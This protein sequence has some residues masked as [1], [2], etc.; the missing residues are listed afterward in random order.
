MRTWFQMSDDKRMVE[1]VAQM[2]RGI[3]DELAVNTASYSY[4]PVYGYYPN[5]YLT[6]C[7][8]ARGWRDKVEPPDEKFGEEEILFNQQGHYGGALSWAY[9]L[10][11]DE[12]VLEL[13][14]RFVNFTLLPKFWSDWPA[15]EYPYVV[16]AEHAHWQGHWHGYVNTLRSVLEYARI[17][18]DTRLLQFVRDGY[19]WARQK[20]I[21][22]IGYVPDG[23]GCALG[24]LIGLAVQMSMAA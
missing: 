9:R 10:T 7:Y 24:R 23:Q 22:R 11:N 17:V 5:D 19:E 6:A 4:I 16:G 21:A 13:A 20:G 8:V 18:N 14:G 15:G 3:R 2:A 1:A 12:E